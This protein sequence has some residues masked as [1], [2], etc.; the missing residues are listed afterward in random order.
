MVGI[1][2]WGAALLSLGYVNLLLTAVVAS[3]QQMI[4]WCMFV[5]EKKMAIHCTNVVS[6]TARKTSASSMA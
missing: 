3:V 5:S 4:A 2:R 1:G 6:V